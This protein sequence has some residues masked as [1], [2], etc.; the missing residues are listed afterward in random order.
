MPTQVGGHSVPVPGQPAEEE[1]EGVLGQRPGGLAVRPPRHQDAGDAVRG[2]HGEGAVAQ[3]EEV[4]E[5][6]ARG[7]EAVRDDGGAEKRV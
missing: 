6:A 3:D 5:A 7:T 4:L 2:V 1:E